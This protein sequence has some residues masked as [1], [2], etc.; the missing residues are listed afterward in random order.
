MPAQ[1]KARYIS[2]GVYACEGGELAAN[3][4]ELRGGVQH[5]GVVSI[6]KLPFFERGREY[7]YA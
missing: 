7:A 6:R 5:G 2:H 3:L 4:V 1:A